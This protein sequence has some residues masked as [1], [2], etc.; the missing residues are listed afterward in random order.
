MGMSD[1]YGPHN[2]AE[3]IEVIKKAIDLGI[4]FFD[5]ADMYGPFTNE[6]LVGKALQKVREKV[7][8]ATKFGNERRADGSWVGINGRPEYVRQACDASLARLGID[9]IDLYYQHRVDR[10]IPIEDTWGALSELVAA[11]KVR[12]LGISEALGPTIRKAHAVHPITAVQSE[13]SLWSREPEINGVFETI[14]ELNIGFVPYSP[15]GRGFLTGSI[16]HTEDLDPSDYRRSHPRFS[17]ENME[18]NMRIVEGVSV[19]ASR[20]GYT[21]A[22]IALAW[23]LNQSQK[24]VPIPGTRKIGRLIENTQA[25]DISLLISDL[26]EL[27]HAAPI[28]A[29][30]GLRYPNMSSVDA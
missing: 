20:L 23:V 10:T 21:P 22:Q 16:T 29:T 19:V 13:Y 28:G 8:I 12:Y 17:Q 5:T 4:N 15:L 18:A 11:G 3:S 24:F 25:S 6:K 9:H 14:N 26:E 27:A 1:F 2:D 7:I 30:Q